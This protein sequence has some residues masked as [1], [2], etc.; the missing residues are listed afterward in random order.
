MLKLFGDIF[1][2][3]FDRFISFFILFFGCF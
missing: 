2:I 3:L 1:M